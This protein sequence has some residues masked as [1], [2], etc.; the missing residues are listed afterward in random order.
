MTAKDAAGR[1]LLLG[2]G[3]EKEFDAQKL[4]QAVASAVKLLD[5]AQPGEAVIAMPVRG[6]D[7][8]ALY[9]DAR[10]SAIAAE[11]EWASRVVDR[12]VA[13]TGDQ[14]TGPY[15]LWVH[16]LDPH[17]PYDPPARYMPNEEVAETK[18]Q[19][20]EPRFYDGEVRAIDDLVGR[21]AAAIERHLRMPHAW[22]VSILLMIMSALIPAAVMEC[23]ACHGGAAQA[24]EINSKAKKQ[25]NY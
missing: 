6:R 12:V 21:V 11:Q 14:P 17:W 22:S 25:N 9:A 19:Q 4:A 16:F 20:L 7:N 18:A 15:F 3:A 2:C 1:V 8:Q 5:A 24:G 10:D 23:D 13:L